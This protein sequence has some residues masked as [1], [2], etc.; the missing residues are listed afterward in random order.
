MD[1]IDRI[2]ELAKSKNLNGVAIGKM[3]GLQKSPLT[4]WKNKKASPTMPQIETLCEIFKVSADYLLFGIESPANRTVP[5]NNDEQEMLNLYSKLD[6][7]GRH[8]LHTIAYEEL[9]RIDYEAQ[10]AEREKSKT[11]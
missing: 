8:R 11:G 3:L 6:S 9:D 7:R 10:R 5:L 4:D 2:F 1:V